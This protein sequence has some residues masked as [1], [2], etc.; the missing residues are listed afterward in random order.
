MRPGLLLFDVRQCRRYSIHADASAWK[1]LHI[2]E[3]ALPQT[4]TGPCVWVVFRGALRV[5]TTERA[6][7]VG[8]GDALI[9][10]AGALEA[11]A[12][13]GCW[14]ICLSWPDG[15]AEVP[16]RRDGLV[17]TQG[18][19]SRT[20]RRAFLALLYSLRGQRDVP[21]GIDHALATAA[22]ECERHCA[23]WKALVVRCRGRSYASRRKCLERL[24]LARHV[25][26]HDV[27]ASWSMA[28]LATLTKYSPSHLVRL[29]QQAFGLSPSEHTAEIR[30][31]R[32]WR[33]VTG[34]DMAMC[35][36]TAEVGFESQ[37][38]FSR[39]F[40][41]RFGS[42]ARAVR[43]CSSIRVDRAQASSRLP[44][45]RPPG[46]TGSAGRALE[47]AEAS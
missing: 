7:T 36:I 26:E 47:R 39:S 31:Q 35:D 27:E 2:D 14:A 13:R 6:W 34:T 5:R 41:L 16:P 29:Y 43:A 23:P 4:S 45:H 19:A 32:A 11:R 33:L 37:S 24:L 3:R 30:Y 44:D 28:S 9:W 20:L 22:E 12:A 42:T 17:L 38:A 18:M 8:S 21:G 40:K 46:R 25:I 15:T 10:P 1:V